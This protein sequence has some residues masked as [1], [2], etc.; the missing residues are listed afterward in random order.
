MLT[1]LMFW[2]CG[3]A[4]L[5]NSRTQ[6]VGVSTSP[7]GARVWVH[8]SDF[9]TPT[10]LTLQRDDQ[11]ILLFT[12]E[13]YEQSSMTLTRRLSPWVLGNVFLLFPV[14]TVLG[15]LVDNY[16]GALW[17]LQPEAVHVVMCKEEP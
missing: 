6:N 1:L 17:V 8:E 11:Y 16:T 14:G 9:F 2:L 3:C 13:G 7:V 4:T 10:V 15:V 5:I 12:K